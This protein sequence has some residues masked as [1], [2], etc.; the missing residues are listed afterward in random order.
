M[1]ETEFAKNHLREHLSGILIG[2]I[3][4]GFWSIHTAAK[5]ACERTNQ[6]AEVI[7]TFQNMI[8]RI[9][10]ITICIFTA[11]GATALW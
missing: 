2:P 11:Q 9:N 6:P 7:K 8:S 4:E 10:F 5:D 1:S 3:S